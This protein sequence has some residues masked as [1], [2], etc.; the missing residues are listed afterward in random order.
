[1][2]KDSISQVEACSVV[3]L[4]HGQCFRVVSVG[5]QHLRVSRHRHNQGSKAPEP[6]AKEPA[7]AEPRAVSR[8]LPIITI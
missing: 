4:A 7:P 1:M 8:K 2:G 6:E 3:T 5:G